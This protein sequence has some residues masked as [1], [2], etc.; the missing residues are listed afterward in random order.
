MESPSTAGNINTSRNDTSLQILDSEDEELVNILQSFELE[1][2][3]KRAAKVIN[4]RL[5]VYF[6]SKSVFNLS[7]KVLT[8]T[9]IRVLEKSLCFYPAPT[10]IN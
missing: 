6:C 5:E 7:K 4:E 3:P 9:D 2:T 8:E 10:K 1:K